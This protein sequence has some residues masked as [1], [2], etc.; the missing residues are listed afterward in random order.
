ML[1]GG[2]LLLM[3][4]PKDKSHIWASLS[5]GS[6]F[7]FII[8]KHILPPHSYVTTGIVGNNVMCKCSLVWIRVCVCV[9][10][11]E[12]TFMHLF[13]CVCLVWL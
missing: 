6:P 12:C 4:H 3:Q 10:V 13:V 8:I 5:V 9:C 2:G 1:P 11:C 7:K